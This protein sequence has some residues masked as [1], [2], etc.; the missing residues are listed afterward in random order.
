M[1]FWDDVF[2]EMLADP[3]YQNQAA[4]GEE[5]GMLPCIAADAWLVQHGYIA[6]PLPFEPRKPKKRKSHGTRSR[7]FARIKTACARIGALLKGGPW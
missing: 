4:I 7:F 6:P 3:D 1:S 5:H 2:G